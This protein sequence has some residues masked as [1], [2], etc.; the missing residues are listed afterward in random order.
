MNYDAVPAALKAI[1]QWVTWLLEDGA[2]KVPYNPRTGKRASSTNAQTWTDFDTAT[3]AAQARKHTGVG[4][5]FTPDD[6]YTGIDLD[7]CIEGDTI[8]PWAQ[9][10]VTTMQ[11]YAEIS[12][13][14]TGIKIWVEGKLPQNIKTQTI[15][16]YSFGRYFTVTGQH[17]ASTPT[18]IRVV[19]GALEQLADSVRP[20]VEEVEQHPILSARVTDSAYLRQWADG[21][22]DSALARLRAAP[23]GTKHNTLLDM[24]R[25]LGGLIPLGLADE[26]TLISLLVQN[27]DAHSEHP[28]TALVTIRDGLAMGM[29]KPLTPPA[30]PPQP[31]FDADGFACCPHHETRLPN[32]KN[33]NGY[34][35]HQKDDGTASNW[36]D[37][38][39]SGEGYV[40]PVEAEQV[41]IAGEIITQAPAAAVQLAPRYQLYKLSGLRALPP[42]EWLIE[43]EIPAALTT[44]VCG[45]SG[46]GKS[47][48][49]VDYA[50]R[51]AR[52][53]PDRIVVYIAPEGGSGYHMRT[54]AWLNHF[55]GDEPENLL[56]ILQAVPLLT[57]Q[58]VSDLI[59]IIRP[60]TP[61]MLI[62]DTLARCL[63]G[64]DENSAKDV[65]M[66]FYHTDMIRQETGAAIA[67]VHHT[68]KSGGGYRGSSVLYG[69]VES[70]IDVTNDDGLITVACG[71]SKDAKPFPPRYLRMVESAGSVV[72][73]PADQVD[74]RNAGLTDPQRK[75]LETLAL[76]IFTG[77][78]REAHR[79][80]ERNQ[81]A[82]TDDVQDSLSAQATWIHQS[83]QARGSLLH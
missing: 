60:F 75:I 1:P 83:G 26:S 22:V 13:S 82:R 80:S 76:D 47:F 52:A 71:K 40:P 2:R 16:L 68:G 48:L 56:F 36:C 32:A 30:A 53:N 59:T 41:V 11:S 24:S 19:N 73:L 20:P 14:G 42:V 37:F 29:T 10:I 39:W 31:L 65:G 70:W 77:P 18:S 7:D 17:L 44:I 50:I 81:Y 43:G 63:V 27:T 67:I 4:F 15:E 66:F 3:R 12:P 21:V 34:K 9:D 38:W 57:P 25:L 69:S 6:P 45:P 8:A 51:V 78:G 72:L 54:Q 61:V 49:M 5:V 23:L 62:V 79:A 46:A 28:H 33:G 64:G 35:C 55:G 58:A 74:Q